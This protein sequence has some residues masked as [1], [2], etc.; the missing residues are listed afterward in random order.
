MI[1]LNENGLFCPK[2]GLYIDP[3]NP[4]DRAVITHAHSDHA[5]W[6]MKSYLSHNQ[7]REILRYRLGE[8]INLETLARYLTEKHLS[9]FAL[10]TLYTGER[11][12]TGDE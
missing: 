1:V 5:R 8:A 11:I 4:V 12:D 9:A 3:W 6:G 2:A 7:S 10:E